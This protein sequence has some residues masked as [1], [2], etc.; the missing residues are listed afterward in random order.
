MKI[1]Y[2][3]IVNRLTALQTFVKPRARVTAMPSRSAAETFDP[4]AYVVDVEGYLPNKSVLEPGL[5][6]IKQLQEISDAQN[7][8]LRKAARLTSIMQTNYMQIE[9]YLSQGSRKPTWDSP[10]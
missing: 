1:M 8:M 4:F 5:K 3:V 7:R 2:S 9:S 6:T 10:R